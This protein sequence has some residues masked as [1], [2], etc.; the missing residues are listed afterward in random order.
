M[1]NGNEV[2]RLP[3]GALDDSEPLELRMASI[4]KAESRLSEVSTVTPARAQEL[5]GYMNQ[6]ALETS[7]HMFKVQY[8][9]LRAKRNY[10]RRKGVLLLDEL[11][12][13][14]EK[15]GIKKA[16]EDIREAFINRDLQIQ[17]LKDRIDALTATLTLLEQKSWSFIRAFNASQLIIKSRMSA[18]S[19]PDLSTGSI[20]GLGG[21]DFG[22]G[23]SDE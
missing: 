9:L 18:A 1:S 6:A 5:M 7:R 16:N 23:F 2:L 13:Y 3:K 17:Q 8:E 19:S 20:Q 22:E 4:Y 14:L 11:E 21:F 15:N 12:A 10:E